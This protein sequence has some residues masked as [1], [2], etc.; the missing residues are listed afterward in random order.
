MVSGY[1]HGYYFWMYVRFWNLMTTFDTDLEIGIEIEKTVLKMLQKK[2]PSATLVNAYKGYD[3]WIPEIHKSV[4]VKLDQKSQHSGNI[5]IEIEMYDKPSGLMATTADLWIIYDGE[6]FLKITPRNIIKCIFLNKLQYIE[7]I[8]K[9]D[10]RTKKAFL[11]PKE[12]LFKYGE[13]L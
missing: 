6:I 11:V 5:V 9:G 10:T 2:F 1:C 12:V 3:I 7:F 13:P 4:E 8:G